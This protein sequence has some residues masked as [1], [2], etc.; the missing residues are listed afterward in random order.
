MGSDKMEKIDLEELRSAVNRVFN[1]I[2]ETRGTSSITLDRTFYW[3]ISFED[4]FN[5]DKKSFDPDIGS[6]ADEW[7]FAK[8]IRT[9][10]SPP[11]AI[12]LCQLAPILDYV[13]H[14]LGD[15]LASEG[16]PGLGGGQLLSSN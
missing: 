1:H 5:M 8:N 3:D 16:G 14:I 9:G 4:R 15:R 7:E 11:L 13:G 12:Q 10:K 2:I 6:L